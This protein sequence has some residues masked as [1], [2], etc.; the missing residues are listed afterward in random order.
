MYNVLR[1]YHRCLAGVKTTKGILAMTLA[2]MLFCQTAPSS[3]PARDTPPKTIVFLGGVKTHGPGAHEHLKGVQFLKQCIET[4]KNTPRVKTQIY[5]DSWPK[6][7]AELDDA[8]TI[9][10]MWEGWDKHLVSRRNPEK[11]KKLDELM[12]RGVGLV[13]MHAA[14]AVEDDVERYYLDWVGGNKKINYSLHPMAHDVELAL[15]A[16]QHPVCRGVR[17]MQFVAEEFYCKIL[18]RPDD[19]RVTPVVT[20]MLPPEHPEKQVVG[21]ACERLDAGRAFACTGPHYHDSFRNED[22]C[23]LVLNAILWTAK[24][25]VPEGGVQS[26][27]IFYLQR[28]RPGAG[29]SSTRVRCWTRS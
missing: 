26:E 20:A 24:I 1:T 8:A 19:K 25:E 15:A 29:A 13:C 16:P 18:F 5:L 27:P 14:T 28:T 22:F 17:P 21:W 7:P 11:V 4:A 9:V 6:D 23:R 3:E 2:S 12:K 10:L